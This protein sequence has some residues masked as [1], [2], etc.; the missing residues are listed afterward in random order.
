[1][2]SGS[3]KPSPE[4]MISGAGCLTVTILQANNLAA[5]DKNGTLVFNF[6]QLIF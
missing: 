3:K 6:S 1:M 5:M 2:F 4:S